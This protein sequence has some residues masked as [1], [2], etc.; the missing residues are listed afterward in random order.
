MAAND[1]DMT[2]AVPV[3]MRAG[4]LLLFHSHLMHK[5]TDNVSST[6]RAAMVYHFGEAGT[7]DQSQEKW[8]LTPPNIDWMSVRRRG[9]A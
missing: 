7:V 9:G 8:G 2:D 4:D 6:R 3:L 1:H 5:S